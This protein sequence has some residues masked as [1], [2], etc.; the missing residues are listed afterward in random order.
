[1]APVMTESKVKPENR[2]KSIRLGTP[3]PTATSN[4]FRIDLPPLAGQG[5]TDI[6]SFTSGIQLMTVDMQLEQP[7][8]FQGV[9][10][11]PSVGFGF[12]LKGGFHSCLDQ[13]FTVHAGDSAFFSFPR[14]VDAFEKVDAKHMIRIYFSLEAE[15]LFKLVHGDEDRFYPVLKS[16]DKRSPY[17]IGH[18][19]T[20]VMKAVLYQ[21]LHCPYHGKTRQL[22]LEGKAME[23]LSHKMAQFD[24]GA[25]SHGTAIKASDTERV[26]QA[27]RL[28]VRDLENPP[29]IMTLANSVGLNRDKLHRC[30]RQVFGLSPF[31][32]LRTQRLQTAMLLLQ[33]GEV[34][35]TQAAIM[36]GYANMSYFTK[37]FKSMF[38]INP[39]KLR[40]VSPACPPN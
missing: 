39:G 34:N 18:G 11:R 28:L 32:Y 37:A 27:A 26:H 22:F 30:F 8:L 33:D 2:M 40:N 25:T 29:D 1:L 38:G 35:V 14:R 9:I 3:Q 7:S 19:I 6:I 36:V 20:P 24:P 15:H 23:L 5:G 31:E 16:L 13:P 4:Q 17:R 10:P 21:M 12:C